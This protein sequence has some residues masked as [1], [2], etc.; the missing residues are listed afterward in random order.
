MAKPYTKKKILETEGLTSGF[1]QYGTDVGGGGSPNSGPKDEEGKGPNSKYRK[2]NNDTMQP[3]T[4]DGKFTYKSVNGKS[5]NP[6]YGPS[7]GKTVNP[8]LTGGENGVMIDQVENEF[9]KKSGE[10]WNKF[11]NKWYQEG[12]EVITNDLKTRVA[13]RPIWETTKEFSERKGEFRGESHDFDQVKV[14]RKSKDEKTARENVAKNGEEQYVIDSKKSGIRVKPGV[15]LPPAPPA[16]QP[17]APSTP[18]GPQPTQPSA[19]V[20]QLTHSMAEIQAARKILEEDGQDTSGYTDE[21]LDQIMDDFLDFDEDDE[22][23]TESL[24]TQNDDSNND[25]ENQEKDEE[26]DSDTIKKIKSMGFNG[27]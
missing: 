21:Q 3:R 1:G 18:N 8:L 24:D 23:D 12:S 2:E 10:Y 6:K 13:A 14:G 17:T 25:S 16:P 9:S 5:I 22:D 20:S 11:K 26:E 7:R 15:Q 27:D 19:S 4:N